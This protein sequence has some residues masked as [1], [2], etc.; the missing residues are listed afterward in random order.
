MP[1]YDKLRTVILLGNVTKSAFYVANL[2][3]IY[4][5]ELKMEK[6]TVYIVH[7][8]TSS[9][10]A[11]WFPWLKRKLMDIGINVTVF[12]MP[13]PNSPVA[14]E[15]DDHLE[16]KIKIRDEN[17][18]FIGHSLGCITLLRY[19]QKQP[20]NIKIG[21]A[22]LVSGFIERLPNYPILDSFI[23]SDLDMEMLTKMVQ[24]RC[25]VSAP[26]DT[27]VAY[28]YSCELAKQFDAKLITVENGGHFI[29]QESFF[30]F[31]QLYDEFCKMI[32]K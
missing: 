1:K 10:E 3:F 31:P 21:G 19:L 9:S 23:K 25:V 18:Y 27:I 17:T 15:W 2:Y 4:M 32:N 29:G 22:I 16:K 14:A 7:G 11:E 5:G 24:N 8:Y 26:N 30:E 20:I 6:V 12:D 13:N 28:K